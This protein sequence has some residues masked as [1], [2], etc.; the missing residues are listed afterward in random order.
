MTRRVCLPTRCLFHWS[1]MQVALL[2]TLGCGTSSAGRSCSTSLRAVYGQTPAET[3]GLRIEQRMVDPTALGGAATASR[4]V[5]CL[6]LTVGLLWQESFVY[7]AS[8]LLILG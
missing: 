3:V 2:S 7:A 8:W 4:C 6:G 1:C 5:C